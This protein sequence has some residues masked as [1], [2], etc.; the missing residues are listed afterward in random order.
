MS[1]HHS[2]DCHVLC[3][4]LSSHRDLVLSAPHYSCYSWFKPRW[5]NTTVDG[6]STV[7]ATTISFG[8]PVHSCVCGPTVT[9]YHTVGFPRGQYTP[10]EPSMPPMFYR[11]ALRLLRTTTRLRPFRYTRIDFAICFIFLFVPLSISS[12]FPSLPFI[13][14]HWI[15]LLSDFRHISFQFKPCALKSRD[16]YCLL[17]D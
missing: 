9:G 7:I 14:G 2:R 6:T 13:P 4:R 8:E 11:L 15:Y 1:N 5:G 10:L 3:K 12:C 17:H 16:I